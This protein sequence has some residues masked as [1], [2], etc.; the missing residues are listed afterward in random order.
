MAAG[1][2][3]PHDR[4]PAVGSCQK[5][6][7][8]STSTTGRALYDD[9]Q[10]QCNLPNAFYHYSETMQ[11]PVRRQHSI[12]VSNLGRRFG[13]PFRVGQSPHK[14]IVIGPLRPRLLTP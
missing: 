13:Q 4:F 10:Q 5:L 6:A 11:K 8:A 7:L 2:K 14:E 12:F 1:T 9:D 3:K